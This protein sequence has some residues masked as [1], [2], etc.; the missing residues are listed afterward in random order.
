MSTSQG[1]R[2]AMA[3]SQQLFLAEPGVVGEVVRADADE[4]QLR[5]VDLGAVLAWVTEGF[6]RDHGV[7]PRTPVV[8][9]SLPNSLIRAFH[10]ALIRLDEI[11]VTVLDE[12]TGAEPFPLDRQQPAQAAVESVDLL[13]PGHRDA[14]QDGADVSLGVALSVGQYQS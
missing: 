2:L 7:F 14:D 5:G 13:W 3:V 4:R 10:Q 6:M 1:A 11:A 8:C 9:G 12:H